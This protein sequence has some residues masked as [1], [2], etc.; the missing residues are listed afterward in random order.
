M[1]RDAVR[2]ANMPAGMGR[3]RAVRR[4]GGVRDDPASHGRGDDGTDALARELEIVALLRSA[5][6]A[7]GPAAAARDRAKQR[8][9]AA[10][11]QEYGR[12]TRR[13]RGTNAM[14]A[15]GP[16]QV[17]APV[18]LA[19]RPRPATPSRRRCAVRRARAAPRGPALRTGAGPVEDPGVE[20]DAELDTSAGCGR[21][22]PG[23]RATPGHSRAALI[24][25]RRGRG[26]RRDRRHRDVRQP[27][28]AARA[29]RCTGS[30]GWRSRPATR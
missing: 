1:H 27:G 15:T 14:E 30:S 4:R 22:R 17:L 6:P 20:D 13:R 29:T 2:T 7:L 5:G 9:M 28:R 12:R 26:A 24:G 16:L 23:H 18:A 11:A 8:L 10:F 3:G 21:T 19:E 25:C